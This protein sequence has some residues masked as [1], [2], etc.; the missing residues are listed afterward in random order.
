[1]KNVVIVDYQLGNLF[2]VQQACNSI[3]LNIKIST[4]KTEI[5]EAGALILPGVGAFGDAINNFTKN[6]SRKSD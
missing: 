3:G 4:D 2:S 6:G 1:M 5:A